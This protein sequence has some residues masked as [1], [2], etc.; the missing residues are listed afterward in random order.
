LGRA[1]TV[2]QLRINPRVFGR[3]QVADLNEFL[4]TVRSLG[5]VSKGPPTMTNKISEPTLRNR[6]AT[7]RGGGHI[8]DLP[9]TAPNPSYRLNLY[10]PIAS[11]WRLYDTSSPDP[12]LIAEGLESQPP[13]VYDEAVWGVVRRQGTA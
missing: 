1:N 6:C 8:T 13:R 4:E 12:R 9:Q 10:E 7:G 2:A 5:N 3:W 11:A